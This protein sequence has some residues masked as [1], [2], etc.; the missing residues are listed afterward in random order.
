[1]VKI[2]KSAKKDRELKQVKIVDTPEPKGTRG[3]E[4]ATPSA[5]AVQT[6]FDLKQ[7]PNL[8]NNFFEW[9]V[10]TS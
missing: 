8:I 2:A 9:N 10:E 3:S 1:M 4:A 7:A 5:H 6:L